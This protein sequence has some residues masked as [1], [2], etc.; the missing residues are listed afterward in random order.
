MYFTGEKLIFTVKFTLYVFTCYMHTTQTLLC[1][2]QTRP[3]KDN[4]IIIM[5][6]D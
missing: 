2:Y 6:C 3:S 5:Y 1:M 4:C